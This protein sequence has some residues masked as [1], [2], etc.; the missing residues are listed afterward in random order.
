MRNYRTGSAPRRGG[1]LLWLVVIVVGVVIFGVYMTSRHQQE[2]LEEADKL[3]KAGQ[4]AAAAEKYK[5][6]YPAAGGRKAEVIKRIVEH[7]A[8]KGSTDEAKK[9]MEKGLDD[10]LTLE[11][12]DADTRALL[13]QVNQEREARLAKQKAEEEEGKRQQAAAKVAGQKKHEAADRIAANKAL[14]REQFRNLILGKTPDQLVA[15]LGKPD[16]TQDTELT[17]TLWYY[18]NV[19]PDPASGKRATKVQLS[20]D[21]FETVKD[22]NF[23]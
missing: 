8:T 2:S 16:Y 19:A 20:F 22:A 21:S 9:W 11:F 15:L 1:V 12:D 3:Y 23:Y 10:K 13:A 14:P 4:K 6:G 18:K 5:A 17:G 7:E